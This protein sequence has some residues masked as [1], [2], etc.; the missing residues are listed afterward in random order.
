MKPTR[1][2][3]VVT[4][5]VLPL[6]YMTTYKVLFGN[7]SQEVQT[8]VIGTIMGTGLGAIMNFWLG[9]SYGSQRKDERA[10]SVTPPNGS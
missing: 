3:M 7:F 6:V 8:L 9:S 5:A 2:T 10:E 4:F 1:Q